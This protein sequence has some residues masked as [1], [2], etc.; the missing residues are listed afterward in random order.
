MGVGG[1]HMPKQIIL[2][3]VPALKYLLDPLVQ[4]G[5]LL[6]RTENPCGDQRQPLTLESQA[7]FFISCA[8]CELS[9]QGFSTVMAPV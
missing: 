7:E 3:S 1:M 2:C 5:F 6:N 8:L 9:H 4:N